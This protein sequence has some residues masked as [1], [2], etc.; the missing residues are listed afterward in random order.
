MSTSPSPAPPQPLDNDDLL[1]E[2]LLRLPP[3]PSSLPRASLV[4]TRWRRLLSSAAFLRRFRARHR[5]P[6]LLGLFKEDSVYPIFIPTLDSPDRIPPAR[7][8]W[9]VPGGSGE[10][11][12]QLFGCRHGRVL[13]YSRRRRLLMVWDPLTG[14]RRA[15]DIPALFHRWDM[16]V[17]HGS[18]RCVDGDGCYSN[19]FEVAV[20][21]T[22]T[23]GTVA[24]ICVYSSKTGNWG[25][26][27]SAPISPGDYMSFSSILDGDFLYWLLGNHGCP[28]LQFNLVKQTATL[29][30]APPD[31]RTNSYGG[32][33]IAPAED[34]GGLVILAV[35]HFSLNVWKGKTNRDGI[36]GWVLEKTIELDRLL[37]F[38]TGPE[39][40]APV[41]LCFAEEHDVVFLSTH[42]GFFMVNMQSMQFKNIPQIL[43]GGLYYPFSSFYTKEAAELLPPCDTSKKPKVPF[44]GAL[45]D[46]EEY[47]SNIG[48]KLVATNSGPRHKKKI[49]PKQTF[50][51]GSLQVEIDPN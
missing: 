36:A 7:F 51:V 15:V 31:L 28:I 49:N 13:H 24:F 27:V 3:Q 16:V 1:S 50:Y 10:D 44:A 4:C 6:P 32:F 34:G 14:D 2:I 45:P 25:N 19:P 22:D 47:G 17:Y 29:V 8:S 23:S 38:G 11:Y 46:I 37:S 5:R 20:V 9:R 30:N 12:H 18:V 41:I 48:E 39:T 26:V 33:H 35:T 43:K 21:G 42:V 40:W